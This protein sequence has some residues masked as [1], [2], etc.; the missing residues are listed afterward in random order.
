MKNVGWIGLLSVLAIVSPGCRAESDAS[1]GGAGG[2]GA[3]GAGAAG[4]GAPDEGTHL[5]VLSQ[6]LGIASFVDAEDVS[7]T[8]EA[9]TFLSS[10]PDTGMYGPRDLEL[11]A[12]GTLYVASENDGSVV[13]Y[14]NA[15]AATGAVKPSRR[16]AGAATGVVSPNALAIDRTAGELYVTNSGA[17]GAGDASIRVFSGLATLDGDV[18]PSRVI[19]PDFASFSPI[20]LTFANGSLYAV[21]Q[22]TASTAVLVFEDAALASGV[23]KPSRTLTDG[24]LGSSASAHV[25]AAGQVLVVDDDASVFVFEPGEVAPS[26]VFDIDGASAL[27]AVHDLPNG[28]YLFADRSQQ[29]VFALDDGL[30]AADGSVPATRSFA[31]LEIT[32]AGAL[33]VP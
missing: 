21:T 11:D 31:S 18:A 5:F 16:L 2:A 30:P 6:N 17:L 32:M 28:A 26:L 27:S 22:T 3:G 13:M 20:A 7:G 15:V 10:G 14:T 33:G 9:T 1:D 4:G 8:V 24:A 19:E 25:T 29:V 23:T 12:A